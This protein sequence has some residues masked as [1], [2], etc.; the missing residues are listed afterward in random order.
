MIAL[1]GF[2][3]YCWLKVLDNINKFI[4]K[5]SGC[6]L[7]QPTLDNPV[8]TEGLDKSL[9]EFPFNLDQPVSLWNTTETREQNE[10]RGKQICN[11][12]VG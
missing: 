12:V 11:I 8:W 7:R 9:P 6:K 10:E 2:R 5:A 3:L 1:T 4:Q